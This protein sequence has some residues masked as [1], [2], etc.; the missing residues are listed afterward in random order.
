MDCTTKEAAETYRDLSYLMLRSERFPGA[1]QPDA[2]DDEDDPTAEELVGLKVCMD[3]F[4]LPMRAIPLTFTARQVHLKGSDEQLGH[5]MS[6]HEGTGAV[7]CRAGDP[8][9]CLVA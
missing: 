8:C 1:E 5:I 4:R 2:E 3:C 6:I 9:H 7:C